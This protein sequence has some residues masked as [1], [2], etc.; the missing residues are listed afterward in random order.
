[1]KKFVALALAVMF[2]SQAGYAE[3]PPIKAPIWQEN[4]S[5]QWKVS[6]PDGGGTSLYGA[7]EAINRVP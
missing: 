3:Q 5:H 1:M 6:S 2:V 4:T 7:T